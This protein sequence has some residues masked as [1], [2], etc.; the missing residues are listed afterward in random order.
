MFLKVGLGNTPPSQVG[1]GQNP[2]KEGAHRQN[3]P[4][5]EFSQ[6]NLEA[7]PSWEE[8][9]KKKKSETPPGMKELYGKLSFALTHQTK[10][11]FGREGAVSVIPCSASGPDGIPW[12]SWAHPLPIPPFTLQALPGG[13]RAL[14]PRERHP[15][16][17]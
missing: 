6:G 10:A 3:H 12:S 5:V 15:A 14:S 4:N 16:S 13:A 8:K 9:K 11:A 17:L 7:A 2:F 1:K